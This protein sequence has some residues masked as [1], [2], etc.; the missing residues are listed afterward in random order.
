M[1]A[2]TY[3]LCGA[4]V[5]TAGCGQKASEEGNAANA[6]AAAKPEPKHYCFFKKDEQKDWTASRGADGNI[7][8]KGRVHMGDPRYKGDLGQP[9]ISGNSAKLWLTMAPVTGYRS[10]DNWWDVSFTIPNSVAVENVT[11]ACD[12]KR[13]FAD[14][15]V[16][17]RK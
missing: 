1:R 13:T 17:P 6:V 14:L 3:L 10:A 16:K 7:T 11:V 5:L 9:E 15:K 8:V 4:L 12:S 2:S